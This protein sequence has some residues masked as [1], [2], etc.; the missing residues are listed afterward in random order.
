M[1]LKNPEDATRTLR[2]LLSGLGLPSEGIKAS[3]T[4]Q[5]IQL[6]SNSGKKLVLSIDD[7]L[8]VKEFA[9]QPKKPLKACDHL[10]LLKRIVWLRNQAAEA[11]GLSEKGNVKFLLRVDDFPRWDLDLDRFLKF[12]NILKKHKIPYLLAVTPNLCLDPL[13]PDSHNFRMLTEKEK[14]T[15]SRITREGVDIALHG[16]SHQTLQ[17]EPYSEFVGLDERTLYSKLELGVKLLG[18]VEIK[19]DFLVPP[20]NT[21][22]NANLTAISALFKG[23]CGGPES[24]CHFGFRMS[25]SYLGKLLYVPSYE[26]AYARAKKVL[27]FVKSAKKLKGDILV[28][29]TLHWSWENDSDFKHVEKLMCAIEGQTV[30]WKTLFGR[31]SG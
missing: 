7:V 6:V 11:L 17:K 19:P 31:G 10:E 27:G 2:I 13:N 4:G 5:K 26:P 9:E 8:L 21:F 18:E 24:F 28:P 30:S 12:H 14:E 15:L 16:L 23:V 29:L 20:F 3:T 22:E 1:I 25:P